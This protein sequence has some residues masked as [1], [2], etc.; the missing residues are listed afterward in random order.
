MQDNEQQD[1]KIRTPLTLRTVRTLLGS[2]TVGTF[3]FFATTTVGCN[4]TS[5]PAKAATQRSTHIKAQGQIL[6]QGGFVRL[7]AAPGDVVEKIKVELN[8][9]VSKNEELV[10]MRSA[11]LA[12]KKRAALAAQI[13]AAE[14]EQALAVS[15][16]NQQIKIA[17]Q[18]LLNI[19]QREQTLPRQYALIKLAEE[20]LAAS[21]EVLRKLEDIAHDQL[22]SEFVGSLEIDRQ[23][24]SVGEANLKLR[25]QR[26]SY[27]QAEEELLY[28][29]QAANTEKELAQEMLDSANKN[30]AV[31][32]IQA[33][34]DALDQEIES[35][36]ILSPINGHIVSINVKE[37]EASAQLPIV[38]LADLSHMV[39]EVEINEMDAARI[40]E[41]DTA[42]VWSRA[43]GQDL[44]GNRNKLA[45]EV[46]I[47]R[48]AMVGRP[49]LKPLDP[50]A[51]TDFRS[52][53]AVIKLDDATEA[54]NWLQ[55]HVQAEITPKV[56]AKD[57][58]APSSK[59]PEASPGTAAEVV[60]DTTADTKV[61]TPGETDIGSAADQEAESKSDGKE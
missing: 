11:S 46:T 55:L 9:K 47:A 37:G 50:L 53:T 48:H 14:E 2:L 26:E 34:L 28:A 15:Q 35:A 10:I 60:D 33:Q 25:Q 54:A 17:D 1:P 61:S 39:C 16:A 22:T 30:S 7:A 19:E 52:V 51:R 8:Q 18:K 5:P 12:A 57:T 29:R 13:T 49:K 43:F 20:Q 41:G 31:K 56:E 32:V 24:I 45:G 21:K 23:R 27:K 6:P 4:K 44:D 42:Q 40:R 59:E 36:R 38:E 3:A 58:D